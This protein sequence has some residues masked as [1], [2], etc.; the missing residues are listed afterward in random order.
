MK[1]DQTPGQDQPMPSYMTFEA[2]HLLGI[3]NPRAIPQKEID[4]R[5]SFLGSLNEARAI[6]ANLPPGPAEILLPTID[7]LDVEWH[8]TED[9]LRY[10]Q[11]YRVEE[12]ISRMLEDL[13]AAK[14]EALMVTVLG[15]TWNPKLDGWDVMMH[16]RKTTFF[17]RD[18]RW[19]WKEDR[20]TYKRGERRG[21]GRAEVPLASL[22]DKDFPELAAE[23]DNLSQFEKY[24]RITDLSR[25]LGWG[26]SGSL[27][28]GHEQGI[29]YEL[30][31]HQKEARQREAALEVEFED[32]AAQ[33]AGELMAH[34][35]LIKDGR[36]G[37]RFEPTITLEAF[38]Y[39]APLRWADFL[40]FLQKQTYS[41]FQGE[42]SKPDTKTPIG[43]E[44][45]SKIYLAALDYLAAQGLRKGPCL[46]CGWESWPVEYKAPGSPGRPPL[47]HEFCPTCVEAKRRA[48]ERGKKRRYLDSKKNDGQ[49]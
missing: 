32:A 34:W 21:F 28:L 25:S 8:A 10:Y 24:K 11:L 20:R 38:N 35:D 7:A 2:W 39:R 4:K 22:L 42:W 27:P 3:L 5:W 16:G 14:R 12:G 49:S 46:S 23:W 33:V 44:R 9:M 36:D 45:A 17:E 18:G 47:S 29:D 13:D 37:E 19:S 48:S 1:N 43:K 31:E 6:A 26:G 15:G 41:G 40:P 30:L